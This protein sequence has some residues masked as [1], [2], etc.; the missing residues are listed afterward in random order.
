MDLFKQRNDRKINTIYYQIGN[1]N[2]LLMNRQVGNTIR[3]LSVCVLDKVKP[4]LLLITWVFSDNRLLTSNKAHFYF[5][6]NERKKKMIASN[7]YIDIL[8]LDRLLACYIFMH[9]GI[10][11]GRNAIR[12]WGST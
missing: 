1:F 7:K 2:H 8:G 10:G 6:N 3:R 4:L 11:V 12:V 9:T 5:L